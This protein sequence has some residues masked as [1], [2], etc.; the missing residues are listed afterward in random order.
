MK[1][2][3]LRYHIDVCRVVGIPDHIVRVAIAI[4]VAHGGPACQ[5]DSHSCGLT[6]CDREASRL[7]RIQRTRDRIAV[8]AR[9]E[10]RIVS[11]IRKG[12]AIRNVVDRY[13]GVR[14]GCASVAGQTTKCAVP[15]CGGVHSANR[16]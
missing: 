11:A 16:K 14:N 8:G 6:I 9:R 5:A 1:T 3:L 13:R 2:L 7:G 12:C 10:D 15:F 4:E